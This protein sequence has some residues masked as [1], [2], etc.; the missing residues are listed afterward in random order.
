VSDRA[1][2]LRI[3]DQL[4]H[5][6]RVA[7]RPRERGTLSLDE[8]AKIAAL[9]GESPRIKTAMLLGALC[10]LRMGEVRGLMPEDR[11]QG[12]LAIRHNYVDDR[13]GAKDPK[14][15]SSRRVPLPG[16]VD[17]LLSLCEAL[18]PKGSRF[19]I[20]NEKDITKPID[21]NAL[22]RGF[23]RVLKEIGIDEDQRRARNLTFH[24]LRHTYVSITRAVGLPDFVVQRLAGHKSAVMMER[25]SHAENVIDFTAARTALEGIVERKTAET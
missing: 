7:E 22:E 16:V 17:E 13:E 4:E 3:P 19:I 12:V 14:C 1:R 2:R 9:E 21:K 11:G 10:G 18:A 15:G 25:Y 24:G 5:L 8:V 23:R 6:Q 20:Y